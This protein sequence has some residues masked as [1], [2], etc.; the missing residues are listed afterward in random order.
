VTY[1]QGRNLFSRAKNSATGSG[2][3]GGAA[4]GSIGVVGA[5]GGGGGGGDNVFNDM[6][7]IIRTKWSNSKVNGI[8]AI[9]E[10]SK[11]ID[12]NFFRLED[13]LAVSF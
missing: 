13:V 6:E 2:V 8:E 9:S 1:A 10:L 5:A 7:S 3:N 12:Q 4:G 11:A